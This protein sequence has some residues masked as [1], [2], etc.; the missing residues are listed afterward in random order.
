MEVEKKRSKGG[1][2]NLF[3]W[4]GKSR[5]KLFSN[6]SELPEGLKQGK[7]NSDNVLK[8]QLNRVEGCENEASSSNKGSSDYNCASSVT[9]DEGGGTK[10]LGVV[11]RLM[12]LDSLPASSVHEPYSTPCLDSSSLRVSHYDRTNLWSDYRPNDYINMPNK[13]ERSSWNPI[14]SRA[15]KVHSGPIERFQ[16]EMLPPKSAKSIPITHHKLLS[17]IKGPGFIPTKNV[18]YIVEAAAKMIEASP[19]ASTKNKASSIGSTSVPLR[20]QNLKEKMEAAHKA[21]RPKRLKESSAFNYTKGQPSNRSHNGSAEYASI[22]KSSANSEKSGSDSLRNKGKSV[23]LAVQAKVNVERRDGPTSSSNRSIMNHREQND[24][25]SNQFVKNQPS[26]QRNAQKRTSANRTSN[27]LRQNNQKQNCVS[28]KD[29]SSSKP[30]VSN[31]LSRRTRST[32]GSIGPNKTVNK[33]VVNSETG[34]KKLSSVATHTEKDLLLSK[35]KNISQKK[36]SANGDVHLEEDVRDNALISN[37]KRSI[38][39]NV[40]IDGCMNWGTDNMNQGMDVVSFTFTS[41]LRRYVPES[42]SSD[43]VMGIN[44]CLS[45]DTL[46][47]RDQPFP[48][49]LKISSHGMNVIGS[50]ALSVL[51]GQKLQELTYRVESSQ[52][53]LVREG[54]DAS[55]ASSLQDSVTSVMSTI[56]REQNKRF[57]FG[58]HNKLDSIHD[59]DCSSIEDLVQNVNQECQGSEGM[60]ENS[61]SSHDIETVEELD[62]LHLRPLSVFEPSS[63]SESF[64]DISQNTNGSMKYSL[65]Q[66]QELS[67]WSS[68]NESLPVEGEIELSDSASSLSTGDVSRKHI[69]RTFILTDLK[70]S[71]NWELEYVRDILSNAELTLEDFVMGQTNKVITPNLFNQLETQGNGTERNGD[72]YFKLGRKILFDCVSEFLDLR[73]R[74]IFIG[75]CKAWA[76]CVKLSGRKG[77][78][79][80]ELCKEILCLKSTE[81]LMVDELVDKD[82]STQDGRWL[83]FDIETFEEGVDIERGILT[84]LVDELVS[85]IL[86]F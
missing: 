22:S 7:E 52:S 5:K 69:S 26:L 30:S 40:A 41:P 1:L 55:L 44:N 72:E 77:W 21:S 16:T 35:T 36:M 20:I 32:N 19:R 70:G 9:S 68:T 2:L 64:S 80:E 17:P 15:Q 65:E 84:S 62:H 76:K 51:L 66:S 34:A 18:A 23:S 8:S 38:K 79:A 14:E 46:G 59:Y 28:N 6:N 4:N 85:D 27:V 25:K 74:Q 67:N 83:D 61:S 10:A 11:A 60:E 63:G 33:V 31:Q 50:D 43:Q 39:C 53:N 42:Q 29:S 24:I 49:N 86:L 12:G 56:S 78:L 73:C 81:D 47:D 37:D 3:D 45:N 48:K 75:S 57:Q 54:T 13:L 58:L 71:N 82:M